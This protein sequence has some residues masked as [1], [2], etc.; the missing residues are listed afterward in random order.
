MEKKNRDSG[1]R[2]SQVE[3]LLQEKGKIE[4]S[5]ERT[6]YFSCGILTADF[7]HTFLQLSYSSE[8]GLLKRLRC[9]KRVFQ[10]LGLPCVT[11]TLSHTKV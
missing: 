1:E 8:W 4:I 6:E 11:I 2:I 5:K 9:M 10:S 7:L 3:D